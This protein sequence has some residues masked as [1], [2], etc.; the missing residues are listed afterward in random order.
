MFSQYKERRANFGKRKGEALCDTVSSTGKPI[1]ATEV[2]LLGCPVWVQTETWGGR[3]GQRVQAVRVTEVPECCFGPRRKDQPSHA[4]SALIPSA[5]SSPRTETGIRG[6][7]KSF[8]WKLPD[9]S[10]PCPSNDT[11]FAAS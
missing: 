11:I 10:L 8:C 7:R 2:L 6:A 5:K 3:H 1:W 4:T 9:G